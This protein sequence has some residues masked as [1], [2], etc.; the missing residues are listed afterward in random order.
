MNRNKYPIVVAGACHNNEFD[1]NL[2]NWLENPHDAYYYGTGALE[3]WGW[4]LTRKIGGGAI[5]CIANT[6]LGMSKE[7]KSTGKGA[8]DYMDLQFFYEYGTNKTDI[9]G[10]C[11]GKA[12]NRYLDAFPIDWDTPSSWDYAYDCK[13]V[14]EWVLLG[15]PSLK[16][17]GYPPEL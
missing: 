16:I 17:G 11:W 4:K 14:Q 1:V 5:A 8:G 3:C 15:D 10:E 9:L 7:D 13:T 12:I 6:G 2:L